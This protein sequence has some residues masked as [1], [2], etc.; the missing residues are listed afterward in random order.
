MKTTIL[1]I[2]AFLNTPWDCH[3]TA[4]DRMG[5]FLDVSELNV[6]TSPMAVFGIVS[7]L[8]DRSPHLHASHHRKKT[9]W[10]TRSR[11]SEPFSSSSPLDLDL[12]GCSFCSFQV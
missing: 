3:R 11:T 1:D 4:D 10:P 7:A 5:C 9:H 8:N 2:L 6:G 12:F